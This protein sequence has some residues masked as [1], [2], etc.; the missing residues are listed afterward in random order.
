MWKVVK[1]QIK[2]KEKC[3]ME[4]RG[5]N[6]LCWK[7]K[8]FCQFFKEKVNKRRGEGAHEKN[9]NSKCASLTAP[10]VV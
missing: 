8:R 2:Q 7:N 4:N 5:E 6:L 1:G 10:V 3:L 9:V